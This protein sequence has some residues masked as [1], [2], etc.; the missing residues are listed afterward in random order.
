MNKNNH[1]NNDTVNENKNMG[2]HPARR[3]LNTE[4]ARRMVEGCTDYNDKRSDKRNFRSVEICGTQFENEDLSGLEAHYSKFKDIQFNACD[5]SRMEGYFIEFENCKFVN[6]DLHNGN[7]SFAQITNAEFINCNLNGIDMPF[8]K[9]DFKTEKCMMECCT[10]QNAELKLN[11]S[12]TNMVG[13]EANAARIEIEAVSCSFRRSEFNGACIKGSIT[14]TDLMNTEFNNAD[15][16]DL[17]LTD[18][19]TRF[20]E[21]KDA[22]GCEDSDTDFED[23]FDDN[24]ED[25]E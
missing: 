3:I 10:A 12:E 25:E 16:T 11:M 24:E 5:L 14:Q 13:L 15:L 9:A 23:I 21:T 2:N 4:E 8:A 6:C 19:A 7:F 22:I 20:M 1:K 18:C 17:R